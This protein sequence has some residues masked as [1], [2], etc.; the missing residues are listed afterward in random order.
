M[1]NTGIVRKL[2]EL[3]RITLPIELRRVLDLGEK[4]PVEIFTDD[5]R[6]VLQ[7]Y[8]ETKCSCGATEKLVEVDGRYYC[9]ECAQKIARKAGLLI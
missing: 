5:D 9:P 8:H 6:I 4:D 3:G 2:D 1:K 7:K